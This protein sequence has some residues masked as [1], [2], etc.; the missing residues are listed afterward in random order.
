MINRFLRFLIGLVGFIIL[1]PCLVLAI[2]A[3]ILFG[4][5]GK[6]V[7]EIPLAMIFQED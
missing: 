6:I 3:W 5:N 4:G 2:P 7:A 1:I